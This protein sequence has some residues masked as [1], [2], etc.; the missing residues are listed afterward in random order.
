MSHEPN[1]PADY[2]KNA[3]VYAGQLI[4]LLHQ[5]SGGPLEAT[6]AGLH[7]YLVTELAV[8]MGGKKAAAVCE[9][10]ADRIRDLPPLPLDGLATARPMGSA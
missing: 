5:L 2:A 7:A 3:A 9:N 6:L 8:L 1:S 10:A 4:G